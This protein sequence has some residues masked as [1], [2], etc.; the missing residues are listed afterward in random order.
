MLRNLIKRIGQA[1]GGVLLLACVAYAVLLLTNLSDKSPTAD[2][3]EVNA[4]LER[5]LPVV[6]SNNAYLYMLGFG[7]PPDDDP[8]A[9][10]RVRYEWMERAAP[11]FPSDEDPLEDDYSFRLQRS[12]VVAELAKTCAESER[13]CIGLLQTDND[14]STEWLSEEAWLLKRY[15]TLIAIPDFKEGFTFELYAPTARYSVILEG[16]RLHLINA[17]RS[18]TNA[19]TTAVKA[20]LE[21]DLVFWRMVLRN[22]DA[23][24]A[25]LIATTSI[26][27]NFKL[28]TLIL[29]RL[30]LEQQ[31]DAIPPSWRT[32]IAD[33][34]RSMSRPFA[35]EAV[36]FS[37][38]TTDALTDNQNLITNWTGG[39]ELPLLDNVLWVVLK[40][41]W[42]TQDSINGYATLMLDLA[43]L[44]YVPYNEIPKAVALAKEKQES[45]FRSF[46]RLYNFTG[47]LVLGNSIADFSS[48]AVRVSDLEGI[49][50]AALLASTIRS[51]GDSNRDVGQYVLTSELVDPYSDEPFEWLADTGLIVF[52]GLE[53]NERARHEF[54]Y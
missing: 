24:I 45:T 42:Q 51:N 30:P 48:Y 27:R 28:G 22:S 33:A 31:T 2:I 44:F 39:T 12:D 25:K 32:P 26:E 10:G 21:R 16:Q 49:R 19:D 52:H 50:R 18:A 34:E 46:S 5:G 41:F 43:H 14:A 8:R 37:D 11:T 1:F 15:Q 17:W 29:R 4:L 6:R 38:F 7:V 3:D 23:I 20:A 36:F 13:E 40:P 9:A 47:D 35:N 54:I 53:P